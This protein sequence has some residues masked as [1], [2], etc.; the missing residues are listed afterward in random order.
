M[1]RN[2]NIHKNKSVGGVEKSPHQ[3]SITS[4]SL[5][6]SQQVLHGHGRQVRVELALIVSAS[7]HEQSPADGSLVCIHVFI[8]LGKMEVTSCLHGNDGVP[9]SRNGE[10]G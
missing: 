6:S 4:N 7:E 8:L 3:V 1:T 2:G 5:K 10:L 9:C